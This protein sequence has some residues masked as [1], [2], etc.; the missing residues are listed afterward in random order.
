MYERREALEKDVKLLKQKLYE[1]FVLLSVLESSLPFQL[2]G[3]TTRAV[4]AR[5]RQESS[6]GIRTEHVKRE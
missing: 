2:G 5:E 6:S 4:A 1:V 3:K